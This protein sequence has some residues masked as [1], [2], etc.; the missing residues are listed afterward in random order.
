MTRHRRT[1]PTPLNDTPPSR[2]KSQHTCANY[3]AITTRPNNNT[4]T[5]IN[6]ATPLQRPQRPTWH[7]DDTDTHLTPATTEFS[8]ERH[9]HCA[10]A[11]KRGRVP[12]GATPFGTPPS[13]PTAAHRTIHR[14][15]HTPPSLHPV[16]GES[17][18]RPRRLP[19]VPRSGSS[20]RAAARPPKQQSPRRDR[21]RRDAG[22]A[23]RRY[24][25]SGFHPGE[26]STTWRR[27][28]NLSVRRERLILIAFVLRLDHTCAIASAM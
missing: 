12:L 19:S 24:R 26:S 7:P 3:S 22:D 8:R 16:S 17:D 21:Y 14:R 5:K 11:I 15:S 28:H 20:S 6:A 13:L 1:T 10:H 18:R 4:T 9:T 25:A 23:R 2:T 27:R